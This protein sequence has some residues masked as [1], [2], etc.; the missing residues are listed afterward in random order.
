MLGFLFN[1]E[2][3]IETKITSIAL[4]ISFKVL[5]QQVKITSILSVEVQVFFFLSPLFTV[6]YFD[7]SYTN[8]IS[9][10]LHNL[11]YC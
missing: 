6:L 9:Y 4:F 3:K 1:I 7:N 11:D 8:Y 10:F 5:V 2:T